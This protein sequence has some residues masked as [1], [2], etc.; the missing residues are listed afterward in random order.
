M[1]STSNLIQVTS[2]AFRDSD[3]AIQTSSVSGRAAFH[4]AG[5]FSGLA[6]DLHLW[7]GGR[8]LSVETKRLDEVLERHA[9]GRTIDF[10]NVDI[11]GHEIVAL[12]SNDWER[13]RPTV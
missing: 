4:S 3:P 1:G 8:T 11:E 6:G 2:V 12:S 5:A 10:M 9:S 7:A 13:F